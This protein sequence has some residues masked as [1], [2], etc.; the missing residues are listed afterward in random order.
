MA[1]AIELKRRRGFSADAF[2]EAAVAKAIAMVHS[3]AKS[4]PAAS[5]EAEHV[6]LALDHALKETFPASDPISIC[7]D[8]V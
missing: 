4:L 5:V 7:V 2:R 3:A 6:D 8:A 1:P